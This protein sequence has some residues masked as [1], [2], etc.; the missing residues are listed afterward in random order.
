MPLKLPSVIGHR[1]N[2]KEWSYE[3][4]TEALQYAL[5]VSDGFETDIE[6]SKDEQIV[7]IHDTFYTGE[8]TLYELAKHLDQTSRQ[9]IGAKRIDELNLSEISGLHLTNGQRIPALDDLTLLV[10]TNPEKFFNIEL[11]ASHSGHIIIER[12]KQENIILNNDHIFFSSFNHLELS[13]I[14][15]RYPDVKIGVLYE[16]GNTK[17]CPMYP[18]FDHDPALYIPFSLQHA[19][20]A[21]IKDLN[22][23]FFCLNEY[24]VG[25]DTLFALRGQYPKSKI[26][27]W[28]YF[29]EPPPQENTR[30]IHT[31]KHLQ[32]ENLLD[33]LAGIITDY[34]AAMH[35][36]LGEI[37]L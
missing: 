27:V 19:Q 31:L 20:T 26:Y 34:P 22:P 23:D 21:E 10:K 3:N 11:K 14:R 9:H 5:K 16:P 4:T 32:R 36:M 37:F 29:T 6:L 2:R 8:K 25:V 24:D 12:F 15:T 13:R 28:W 7:V 17:Q 30:F 18:W 33:M 35:K 1:G